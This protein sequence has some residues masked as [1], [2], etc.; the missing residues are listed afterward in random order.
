MGWNSWNRFGPFISERL[1]LE[2]ADALTESG[3]RDAGYRYVVIDDAWEESVRSDDGELVENRW[4]FPHGMAWLGERIHERGLRFGLYTCAGTRTCQGYPASRGFE[5]RDAKRFAEWGVDFMK[6]DWCHSEGLRG[7]ETYPRWSEA[8]RATRRP[9]VLSLCEWGRDRPWEWA[10]TVG[11]MWR[12]AGDIV[13]TWESLMRTVDR[14]VDLHPHSGPDHWNDPDMLEV[15]NGG[16]SDE[17]YRTH[18]SLWAM[19]AAP[20]MAGNDVRDMSDS[21]RALLT[22][23]EVVAIDQDALGRQARRVRA[24]D[25]EIWRRDLA[26]GGHAL[27][28][29]NRDERE[30]G[31]SVAWPE[32]GLAPGTP[33]R[34]RD[35]WERSDLGVVDE[36]IDAALAPHACAL[37][38]LSPV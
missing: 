23:P 4:A 36:G 30:R 16:M 32:L 29:L 18:M 34:V 15:G 2:T 9:M 6:V 27:L 12:T 7:R 1:V 17:E 19:L 10:G 22:A 21:T 26:D 31:V 3:M 14:Q 38:R 24:N 35:A 37:F 20:L 8:I 5:A 25:G 33:L 11:H 13:D 28:L